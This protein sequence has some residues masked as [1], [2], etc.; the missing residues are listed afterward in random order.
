MKGFIK[1]LLREELLNEVRVLNPYITKLYNEEGLKDSD[2]IRVYHGFN[3]YEYAVTA[4]KF[5]LSGKEK[6]KRIYSYE[7]NNNPYGLFITLDLDT[8]KKFTYPTGDK[9]ICVIFELN[10]KVSDL[11][12][13]VWPSGSYTVQG[14][15]A[16]YWKDDEDR[17]KNG[18]LVAREVAK[19]EYS[20]SKFVMNADRPEL[21]AT[22]VGNERQALFI[23][24]INP[25]MIKNIWYG[26]GGKHGYSPKNYERIS[27]KEFLNKFKN[28]KPEKNVY[29]GMSNTEQDFHDKKNMLF[30]PNDDFSMEKLDKY[31]NDNNSGYNN[32]VEFIKILGKYNEINR[33]FWP[34]QINQ[35]KQSGLL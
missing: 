18:T 32:G 10:V 13:P 33:Y 4:A 31:L 14:Q 29:G 24:D 3:N 11:E 22:L 28:F 6:A 5:G 12:A 15:M 26:E 17:Y 23:G 19:K 27:I 2:T 8:A 20:D 9:G 35:M 16:K 30:K 1:T 7:S 34:K 21:A 25:N